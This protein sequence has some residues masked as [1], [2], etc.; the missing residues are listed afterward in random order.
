MSISTKPRYKLRPI[1]AHLHA[2]KESLRWLEERKYE[3]FQQEPYTAS[4][5]AQLFSLV[6]AAAQAHVSER[7]EVEGAAYPRKST[8][9]GR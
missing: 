2:C 6:D 7:D 5:L 3:T 4:E 9:Q 1:L 8:G